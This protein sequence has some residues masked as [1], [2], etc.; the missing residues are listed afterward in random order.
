MR[1][2]CSYYSSFLK[3]LKAKRGS[4]ETFKNNHIWL[5]AVCIVEQ[6]YLINRIEIIQLVR[7][8]NF[9]KNLHFLSHDTY[10]YVYVP[11]VKKC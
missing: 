2:S 8:E 9:P 7:L 5:S 3:K 1:F 6:Y 11:G 10:T 4:K